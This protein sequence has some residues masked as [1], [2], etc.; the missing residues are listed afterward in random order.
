M[1][2][3]GTSPSL[4]PWALSVIGVPL[5]QSMRA[6]GGVAGHG[7]SGQVGYFMDSQ[8]VRFYLSVFFRRL[9][10]FL[11]PFVAVTVTGCL[12]AFL[13]PPGYLAVAKILV[14][15][16][17]VSA[18]LAR[19]SVPADALQQVL[20]LEQQLTTRASLLAMAEKFAIYPAADMSSDDVAGDMRERT[21]VEPIEVSNLG[22]NNGAIAFAISF[23]A[24]DPAL[25]ANVA[26]A[27]AN[28]ILEMNARERKARAADA[29]EFFKRDV[30]RLQVVLTQTQ[31]AILRF[32][33]GHRDALPDNLEFHRMQQNTYEERLRQLQRE[34]A[35]LQQRRS[36][37][38]Q[39]LDAPIGRAPTAE[40]Q[41]LADLRRVLAEQEAMFSDDS[42]NLRSLRTR[43]ADLEKR[44]MEARA[45]PKDIH[46]RTD[47]SPELRV[48]F[49]DLD[50]QFAFIAQ[51]KETVA[52]ALADLARSIADTETNSTILSSLERNYENAQTQHNDAVA[53]L[54]EASTGQRI[55]TEAVGQKLTLIEP[56]TP[57]QKPIRPRRSAIAAGGLAAGIGLGLGLVLLLEFWSPSIR[58]PADLASAF[59]GQPFA[60]IPYI[61]TGREVLMHR[62]ATAGLVVALL[63]SVPALLLVREHFPAPVTAA[64][65]SISKEIR[66]SPSR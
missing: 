45:A 6:A 18:D 48:Q 9:R 24:G 39:I 63:G 34:E 36:T 30:E 17:R 4:Q 32:K 58:R 22:D 54:A 55:E 8:D 13:L 5:R 53:R 59:D 51:E 43:I 26:N 42:P 11:V 19:P 16:P 57:P 12:V 52:R 28:A 46:E 64:L 61:S 29:H 31:D 3:R 65:S 25:A 23:E 15:S 14:E 35:S 27:Y 62:M 44:L 7:R 47:I 56:A 66:T 2:P 33:E 41:R 49:A 21:K 50:G 40:D 1:A 10:Y 60:T 37:I 20:V 38:E